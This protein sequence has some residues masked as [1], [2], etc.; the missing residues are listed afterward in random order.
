MNRKRRRCLEAVGAG[1]A[2]TA[3]AGCLDELTEDDGETRTTEGGSDGGETGDDGG[4]D[5]DDTDDGGREVDREI[6][7]AA[8]RF[9]RAGASLRESQGNLED[10][11]GTDYDPDEPTAFLEEGREALEAAEEAGPDDDQATDIDEL[12]DYADVLEALID[13]TAVV[14]DD[15]L[16]DDV[17][18]IND[19]IVAEDLATART[20]AEALATRF[21]DAQLAVEAALESLD[22]LDEDRLADLAISDLDDV[23]E[24]GELL[25]SVV[26]SLVILST[27]MVSMVTG[28]EH[29]E[30]GGEL[31]EEER[32]ED[33]IEAFEEAEAVYVETAGDL[34]GGRAAA[35]QGLVEYFDVALC[36]TAALEDAA[37]AFREGAEAAA[38]DDPL[39]A[40]EREAD[41][42][43]A[44]E[45]A[46]A[47]AE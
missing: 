34:E 25:A 30:E 20:E 31:A 29:L 38:D 10:P 37:T 35:P 24:G 13:G 16:E 14:T 23:E 47:C 6:R 32:F 1:V 41:G 5:T 26:D 11:E 7:T 39:T 15:A 8:G 28:H 2:L 12:A 19:A 22:A 33:A 44:L 46:E 3:L 9:N 36:Q 17:D 27:A 40:E 43:A 21:E 45:D 4:D 42:E 18:A